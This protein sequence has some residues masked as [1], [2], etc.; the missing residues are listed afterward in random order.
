MI[1]LWVVI[2][3]VSLAILILG[4]E[5][6]LI[7]AQKIGLKIGLSPFVV[8]MTIVAFGTSLPELVS[9]IVANFRGL[10]EFAVANAV[11]S[12]IANIL[13]VIGIATLFARKLQ[14]TKDLIN[15]DLPLLAISTSIFLLVAWDGKI[16]FFESLFLLATYIIYVGFT[17]IYEDNDEEESDSP[18]VY[19]LDY[20]KLIFGIAGLSLGASYLINS[21]EQLA[22]IFN[23][24]TGI[25]AITAVAIGT[26]LPEIIVSVKAA[27]RRQSEVAL[28]NIFGSNVFNILMVVGL[29]GLFGT[30]YLDSQ[31]MLVGLPV[32]IIS[33]LLF[34]ISGIS[35]KIHV[36]EGALFLLLYV[37]FIAKLFNLF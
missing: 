10:N 9:A 25:I 36:Q 28:G 35:R 21:V 8:G 17:L 32:L 18:K 26:S 3:I 29:P 19:V 22:L 4:A 34:V 2:F 12:N 27:I 23:I 14:V 37:I 30:L 15:L 33:T 20:I 1:L 31:T 16:N 5:W 13:L 6:L 7:S 24:S 11:G